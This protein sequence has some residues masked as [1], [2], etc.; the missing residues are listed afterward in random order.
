[1]KIVMTECL[2]CDGF[3]VAVVCFYTKTVA[4]YSCRLVQCRD[5]QFRPFDP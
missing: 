3:V 5:P 2:W 4:E 1:M